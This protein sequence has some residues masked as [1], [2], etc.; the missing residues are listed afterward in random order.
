MLLAFADTHAL[1][2]GHATIHTGSG[3]LSYA[4]MTGV[5]DLKL[6]NGGVSLNSTVGEL[7]DLGC[8]KALI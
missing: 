7:M 3:T 5:T 4:N 6:Y 8:V 1:T 2:G